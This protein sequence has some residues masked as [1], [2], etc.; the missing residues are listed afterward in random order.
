MIEE[1]ADEGDAEEEGGK[2]AGPTSEDHRVILSEHERPLGVVRDCYNSPMKINA[3]NWVGSLLSASVLLGV[4]GCQTDGA[5]TS[6]QSQESVDL[7]TLLRAHPEMFADVLER[8]DEL[9]LKIELAVVTPGPDGPVLVRDALHH[10]PDYFYPASSVKTCAVLAAFQ[11]IDRLERESGASIDRDTALRFHP[12]FPGEEMETTDPSHV[13]GQTITAAHD[14]RKV[15]LV[16]DNAA[17]NRLYELSGP[18]V[19]N[20][21]MRAAGLESSLI[22]HRLSEF[23]SPEDQLRLPRVEFVEDG[24][25]LAA[26][27]ARVAPSQGTNAGLSGLV[28]GKAHLAGNDGM[29]D[30]PMSFLHKNW[31]ALRDLLDMNVLMLRPDVRVDGSAVGF[32]L[33]EG[34]RA[35]IREAMASTP[36]GSTDPVYDA[37]EYPDEFSKFLGPGVWR[38]RDRGEVVIRDKIGRAYGFS[39]TNSEVTCERTGR[40]FFLAATIYTNANE[41]VGDGVYEYDVADTFFADLGEV[42]A[43]AV[44]GE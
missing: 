24:E 18:D 20:E 7:A 15:F 23:H 2:R 39:T 14:A 36:A 10:G 9:R 1:C 4:L 22:V 29:V 26:R 11:T 41:R 40:T 5:T 13:D 35:F 19:I 16:S 31:I 28:F 37:A 44:F 3:A 34:D 12:L 33:S 30:G 25:V 42:V 32:E 17:Y 38:V 8:A 27:P 43:R 6:A 21:M